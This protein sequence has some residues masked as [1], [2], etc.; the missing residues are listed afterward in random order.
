[1]T[2]AIL[3]AILSLFGTAIGSVASVLTAN[4]LTNYKIEVL[5]KEIIELRDETKKHNQIIERTY[6]L[7]EAVEI[8]RVD[9]GQLE[10][11]IALLEGGH[12]R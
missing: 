10:K 7:E 12:K 2:E 5:Q 6:K 4:K 9:R 3:V 11:R 1:M 8:A